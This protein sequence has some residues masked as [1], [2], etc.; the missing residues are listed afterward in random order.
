MEHQPPGEDGNTQAP[1]PVWSAPQRA[2]GQPDQ[3]GGD[4]QNERAVGL[5]GI[6]PP[7]LHQ[8]G[9]GIPE[10]QSQQGDYES[11]G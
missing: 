5:V 7:G 2:A 4:Q 6:A 9:Q 8:P 3:D 11:N 10:G 1:G